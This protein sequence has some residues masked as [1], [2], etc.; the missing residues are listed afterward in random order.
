MFFCRD[1]G[2]YIITVLNI[3]IYIFQLQ[4][5]CENL[6]KTINL[7]I[8]RLKFSAHDIDTGKEI[9]E[10]V[11]SEPIHNMSKLLQ[12]FFCIQIL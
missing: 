7:N 12:I 4:V 11:Y 5:Q 8:V 1:C 9:C 10:P 2:E 6:A 3:L